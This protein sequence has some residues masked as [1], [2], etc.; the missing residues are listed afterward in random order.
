MKRT[1]VT[2]KSPNAPPDDPDAES[3][4]SVSLLVRRQHARMP[5]THSCPSAIVA[6]VL[7]AVAGTSRAGETRQW[8]TLTNC[9][10]VASKSND[11]DSFRVRSGTNE[12]TLRLYYVDAPETTLTYPERVPQQSEHYAITLDETLKAGAKARE[13]V[14]ELL[15]ESFIVRTRR[16]NAAGRGGQTR[17][18]GIVEVGG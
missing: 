13:K 6:L 16:A 8:V 7:L 11:G 3:G 1:S 17:Y 2:N 14:K 5:T 9:Q 15:R 4:R 10:F 18:Y 12:F